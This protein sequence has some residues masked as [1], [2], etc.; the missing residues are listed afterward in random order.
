M[1][2]PRKLGMSMRS[3]RPY[4][5]KDASAECVSTALDLISSTEAIFADS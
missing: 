2:T 3:S 4:G 1:T 5:S